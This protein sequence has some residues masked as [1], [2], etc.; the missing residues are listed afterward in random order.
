MTQDHNTLDIITLRRM[1][2]LTQDELAH[3]LKINPRTVRRWEQGSPVHLIWQDRLTTMYRNRFPESE[4]PR[5]VRAKV[6]E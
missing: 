4:P 1:L 3:A 2:G 5:L 6:S